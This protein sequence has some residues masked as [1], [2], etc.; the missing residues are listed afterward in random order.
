LKGSLGQMTGNTTTII[1]AMAAHKFLLQE[2]R[3]S[4][5]RKQPGHDCTQTDQHH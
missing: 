2:R 4:K 3:I 5:K 1:K